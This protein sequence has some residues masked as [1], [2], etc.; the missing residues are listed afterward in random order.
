MR[1]EAHFIITL[2]T[3]VGFEVHFCQHLTKKFGDGRADED[4]PGFGEFFPT[5]FTLHAD[6]N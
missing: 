6:H 1:P 4:A 3:E 5:C 2:H